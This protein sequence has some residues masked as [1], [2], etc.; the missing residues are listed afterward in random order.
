[1]RLDFGHPP[2]HAQYA[3]SGLTGF[4][5]KVEQT[6][7]GIP[8]SLSAEL[9][10]LGLN[11]ENFLQGY[12]KDDEDGWSKDVSMD[13]V[14]LDQYD[15]SMQRTTS[16]SSAST[17]KRRTLD[18]TADNSLFSNVT[19]SSSGL[20]DS[21]FSNADPSASRWVHGRDTPPNLTP[22]SYKQQEQKS[23]S[24]SMLD[25]A[26]M[27]LQYAQTWPRS[28][29][30]ASSGE[31]S[32]AQHTPSMTHSSGMVGPSSDIVI[33]EYAG[34]GNA[35]QLLSPIQHS[36]SDNV[37]LRQTADTA[38]FASSGPP[39]SQQLK[40]TIVRRMHS[41][42]GE[43]SERGPSARLSLARMT[44]MMA[45]PQQQKAGQQ[46]N[47]RRSDKK[48]WSMS[49]MAGG[50]SQA[51]RPTDQ[52]EEVSAALD[53]LR[54]FLRQRDRKGQP[55]STQSPH[56]FQ[57]PT[58][59]PPSSSSRRSS[60]AYDAGLTQPLNPIVQ[61]TDFGMAGYGTMELGRTDDSGS[62]QA[63]QPRLRHSAKPLPP[64]GALLRSISG[65][66]VAYS[67]S[68]HPN[69]R[70][71]YATTSNSFQEI[72]SDHRHTPSLSPSSSF[73][74]SLPHRPRQRSSHSSFASSYSGMHANTT[75]VDRIA[76]LENLAE[77]LQRMREADRQ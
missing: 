3:A 61:Q 15:I 49:I 52:Y 32:S 48:R 10:G 71:Q 51:N 29:S 43:R 16:S 59:D 76:T 45:D 46:S 70:Q 33:N 37:L 47:T 66:P 67:E 21:I 54:T 35:D 55:A 18:G 23:S 5:S 36:Y 64:R 14:Q 60:D 75:N 25:V 20:E 58:F 6:G 17:T 77:R 7:S 11:A 2:R 28:L 26:N 31:V 30:D 44:N 62:G 1:L 72:T 34:P 22:P 41:G 4:E 42:G 9:A 57:Q 8:T 50:A 38:S 74:D 56:F 53:K 12:G 40:P 63:E 73:F 27:R 13:E 69:R 19:S 65:M 68:N 39:S 24:S